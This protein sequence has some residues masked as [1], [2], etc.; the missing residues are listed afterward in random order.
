MVREL[1]DFL[2]RRWTESETPKMNA[3]VLRRHWPIVVPFVLAVTM[4][5]AWFIPGL[6]TG[7]DFTSHDAGDLLR[8]FPWGSAWDSSMLFGF[9]S[10][11]IPSFPLWA[12][13]GLL[14]HMGASW[15]IIERLLW[16][17]PWLILVIIS[18]YALTYCL[19]KSAGASALASTM[20]A[21]NTWTVGLIQR[22]HLASLVAASVM[23][24]AFLALFEILRGRSAKAPLLFGLIILFQ[25][26]YDV[27]YAYITCL[28]CVVASI[29][30]ALQVIRRR[31]MWGRVAT[32]VVMTCVSVLVLSLYW[33]AP[34]IV[35]PMQLPSGYGGIAEFLAVSAA[36]SLSRSL[37]LYFPY[38]RYIVGES[39]FAVADPPLYFYLLTAAV[40]ISAIVS[41]RTTYGRAF[42]VVAVFAAVVVAGPDSFAGWFDRLLFLH[43]PGMKLFRD[44]SKWMSLEMLAAAVLVAFG[45]A[46]LERIF[47]SRL[48]RFVPITGFALALV[49]YVA[50][51]NQAWNPHRGSNF[52][53][54]SMREEDVA[55]TDLINRAADGRRI[56]FFPHFL[57]RY[58]STVKRPL[59]SGGEINSFMRPFGFG[60]LSPDVSDLFAFYDNRLA[61]GLLRFLGVQYVIVP[62]DPDQTL[63]TP[64]GF[65]VSRSS[66]ISF[67]DKQPWL[68]R[69][70]GKSAVTAYIVRGATSPTPQLMQAVTTNDISQSQR[71]SELAS[72]PPVYALVARNDLLRVGVCASAVY[73]FVP[74]DKLRQGSNRIDA[75]CR[76][77]LVGYSYSLFDQSIINSYMPTE[78][79]QVRLSVDEPRAYIGRA[80]FDT[81]LKSTLSFLNRAKISRCSHFVSGHHWID[82]SA[83]SNAGC[84]VQFSVPFEARKYSNLNVRYLLDS[85]ANANVRIRYEKTPSLKTLHL[86]SEAVS[87]HFDMGPNDSALG[88]EKI[89]VELAA[90]G[91]L[92]HLLL[93]DLYAQRN[94][95]AR[96]PLSVLTR[97]NV[98]APMGVTPGNKAFCPNGRDGS[99]GFASGEAVITIPPQHANH[100]RALI[101][102]FDLR[103]R[104][105]PSGTFEFDIAAPPDIEILPLP[106]VSK[107]TPELFKRFSESHF[108]DEI[109]SL[110]H[111]AIGPG[112]S[113]QSEKWA[114]YA[115]D[116]DR[117]TAL[118]GHHINQID[119]I[120]VFLTSRK[121][122]SR[123]AFGGFRVILGGFMTSNDGATPKDE[124][125]I[126]IDDKTIRFPVRGQSGGSAQFDVTLSRGLHSLLVPEHNS[127]FVRGVSLSTG[128]L[129][130]AGSARVVDDVSSTEQV[131]EYWGNS[132]SQ[133]LV[134]PHAY[135]G[136]W[137]VANIPKSA[138]L[139]LTGDPVRDYIKI[140]QWVFPANRHVVVD[141]LLDGWSLPER[142]GRVVSFYYPELIVKVS[143]YV[144]MAAVLLLTGC[145]LGAHLKKRALDFSRLQRRVDVK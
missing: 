138:Q 14:A 131:V 95:T 23:P 117:Y 91:H 118:T 122:G 71:V 65:D 16:L 143:F 80:E 38:Y 50:I 27:R 15:G 17:F 34:Q 137:M 44:I 26:V 144:W 39:S 114:H 77:N 25:A 22:G 6:I 128:R 43:L 123:R 61:P 79:L 104:I 2:Q 42:V 108:V 75:Q 89:S 64:W 98:I 24:L 145:L 76:P 4:C 102:T 52:S 67:L 45:F 83:N 130:P 88:Q 41:L 12:M 8:L 99:V 81:R 63:Y 90:K 70:V 100:G 18:P 126:N 94:V 51:M 54:T 110:H 129:P 7:D 87:E 66:I 60:A 133:L 127:Q 37:A 32:A 46:K 53:V 106:L 62:D 109:A 57:P 97:E 13:A 121:R 21:I 58:S 115:L 134:F 86:R 72:L 119:G 73:T 96:S 111:V 78:P 59:V 35:Y 33:L 11:N 74:H 20:F 92:T 48:R 49:A 47:T 124:I 113:R 116:L 36:H 85:G 5:R 105:S 141:G 31:R 69:Y 82:L 10:E 19:T 40:V 56:L 55:T 140:R 142:K 68:Q 30:M 29:F 125:R 28:G 3:R 112:L 107:S 132:P 1:S 136:G 93:L 103:R 120:R 101:C 9:P 84:S 139:T 135:D